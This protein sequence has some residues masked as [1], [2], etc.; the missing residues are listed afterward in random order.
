MQKIAQAGKPGAHELPAALEPTCWE[1]ATLLPIT[2]AKLSAGWTPVDTEKDPVY[3]ES[4][5]RTHAMLRGAV[6]CDRDGASVTVRWV[7]TTV[8]IS[9]IP[10]GE[11]SLLEAVVD[12]GQPV[13]AERVQKE[14]T[15]HARFWYLP[16]QK[17]GEHT[18][19]FTVKKL[20]AGQSFYLG[21]LLIVGRPVR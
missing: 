20:P 3:T 10:Y 12:G 17:P 1:T 8:G 21:Q 13:T 15:R 11:P 4:R 19:T 7:G 2:R 14:K 5:A 18:V 16:E 9:D 6:K